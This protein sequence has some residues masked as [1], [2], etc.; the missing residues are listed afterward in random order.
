LEKKGK[1]LLNLVILFSLLSQGVFSQAKSGL[2]NYNQLSGRSEYLWMPIMH[3]QANNGIYGE[4]RYNYEDANTVSLFA[5]KLFE[6]GKGI[7][8]SFVPM[9]GF[10]SGNFTG[11][12]VALNSDIEWKRLYFSSQSQFSIATNKGINNFFFSWSEAGINFSDIFFAGTALQFTYQQK[13]S[14][15]DPGLVAGFDIK[16]F[17]IPVYVF[18][19]FNSD[20]Y[21]IVGL[22]FEFNFKR[23]K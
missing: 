23:R 20:N 14:K 12:S 9:L 15:V 10:S 17:S 4:F 19:P 11:A 13:R 18:N 7:E 16:N 6:G 22:N 3:Y 21:F 8:Y 1:K 5:G 2:E